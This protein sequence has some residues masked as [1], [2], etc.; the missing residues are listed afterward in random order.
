MALHTT[1]KLFWRFM[2]LVGLGFNR[3]RIVARYLRINR[4]GRDDFL[5]G[6]G[7][8]CCDARPRYAQAQA[9]LRKLRR[10]NL[11]LHSSPTPPLTS[12]ASNA[13]ATPVFHEVNKRVLLYPKLSSARDA[14]RVLAVAPQPTESRQ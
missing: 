3:C 8:G 14:T 7:F 12:Y 13:K 4:T 1:P 6:Q 9:R 2:C 11:R 5:V 10:H